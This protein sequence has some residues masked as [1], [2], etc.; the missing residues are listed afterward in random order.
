[1]FPNNPESMFKH[2]ADIHFDI[3]IGTHL[4]AKYR[5]VQNFSARLWKDEIH[6]PHKNRWPGVIYIDR[7]GRE[8]QYYAGT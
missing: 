3:F 1:M 6:F 4:T 8:F 2:L 5:N 7:A